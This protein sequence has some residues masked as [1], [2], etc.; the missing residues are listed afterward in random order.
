MLNHVIAVSLLLQLPTSFPSSVI[1]QT[2]QISLGAFHS[3]SAR[4]TYKKTEDPLRVS[5]L[6]SNRHHFHS[7]EANRLFVSI[8][9]PSYQYVHSWTWQTISQLWLALCEI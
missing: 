2:L 6:M 4:M 8:T 3:H 5:C 7:Y 1:E 9:G